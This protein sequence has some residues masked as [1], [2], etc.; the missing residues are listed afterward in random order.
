MLMCKLLLIPQDFKCFGTFFMKLKNKTSLKIRKV[1]HI[2]GYPDRIRTHGMS[3][4]E[5]DAL[6]LGY[7]VIT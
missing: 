6:P 2:F 4:P 3:G 1:I 7:W 5:P